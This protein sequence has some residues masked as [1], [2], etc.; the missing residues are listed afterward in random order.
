MTPSEQEPARTLPE[1][2]AF[3]VGPVFIDI[4]LAGLD[5]AP[6]LGTESWARSMGTCPGGIANIAVALSRLGL[7][8]SLA[9][10]FGDDAYGDFC[11]ESL[12]LGEGIDLS[13]SVRMTGKHTPLTIS[14]AY[15]SD[16]TMVSHGHLHEHP[17]I[18]IDA[19]PRA[20]VAFAS[21]GG[22][23]N[24][25]WLAAAKA[26][27]ARVVV[28]SG[29]Q[30]DGEWD[31]DRLGDLSL[32]DVFIVNGPEALA[33]TG[34]TRLEDAALALAERV[35]LPVVTR[36]SRGAIAVDREAVDAEHR[37]VDV[38]GIDIEPVDPTG[39]GDVFAAGLAAG[40]VWSLTIEQ[41]L[42]LATVAAGLS[43]EDI[44][45][46]F[47]APSLE[48]IAQ[49]YRDSAREHDA[50]FAE[51]YG[52]LDELHSTWGRQRRPRRA[53]PTIGFRA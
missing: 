37:I 49:W 47:S 29:W 40:L 36:G 15:D 18:S 17:G 51:R 10:A 42:V 53:I 33:W 1:F 7:N 9:T 44:G 2:D 35:P 16:R 27:G 38:G 34:T 4:V 45:G 46:S 20:A 21:I 43:V 14:L 5:H 3:V 50:A 39:A 6:V 28:T 48:G 25:A 8:T 32:A 12:E 22:D 24:T 30:P 11:R 31:L 52:F 19:V 13:R 26:N 41:S 23:Q